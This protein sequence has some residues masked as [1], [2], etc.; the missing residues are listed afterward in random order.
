MPNVGHIVFVT[1]LFHFVDLQIYVKI[2]FDITTELLLSAFSERCIV[3]AKMEKHRTRKK[4]LNIFLPCT[5]GQTLAF[6]QKEKELGY[7]HFYF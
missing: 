3:S 7:E 2:L 5:V 6:E 1:K 4:V